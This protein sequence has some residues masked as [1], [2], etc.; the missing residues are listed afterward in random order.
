[1]TTNESLPI[2]PDIARMAK[3]RAATAVAILLMA[4]ATL[5][6]MTAVAYLALR[7][8][9]QSTDNGQ[10][11]KTVTA[12]NE[13]L[14]DCTEPGGKCYEEGQARTGEAVGMLIEDS[15]ASS[16]VT[17][18]VVVLAAVCD[19]QSKIR[20]TENAAKRFVLM[21]KCINSKLEKGSPQ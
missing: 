2:D 9:D 8:S 10:Q 17:R 5:I 21:E 14:L 3:V 6:A 18:Q 1:M 20:T 19:A 15:S 7:A 11:L 4:L 13:R 12:I 16:R